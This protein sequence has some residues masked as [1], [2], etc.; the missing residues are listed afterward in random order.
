MN[1]K[2]PTVNNRQKRLG[3]SYTK[4][5]R[6]TDMFD[7]RFPN[8][9]F[10]TGLEKGSICLTTDGCK[11]SCVGYIIKKKK[12]KG[13]LVFYSWVG[14]RTLQHNPI[15]EK[16][17]MDEFLEKILKRVQHQLRDV[18]KQNL[19]KLFREKQNQLFQMEVEAV[20]KEF[21][22]EFKSYNNN[23]GIS[24]SDDVV[25]TKSENRKYYVQM[26]CRMTREKYLE[27]IQFY[28]KFKD[29]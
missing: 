15:S 8:E 11:G 18:H 28:N 24:I 1:K 7:A 26:K 22:P 25:V 27:F 13:T 21:I 19:T 5:I 23:G 3:K 4:M 20:T 6:I 12:T 17:G 9:H 2:K 16:K 14:K 10:N 29:S